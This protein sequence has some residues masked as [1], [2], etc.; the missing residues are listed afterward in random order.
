MSKTST[1]GERVATRFAAAVLDD[2]MKALLLKLRKG[3]DSSLSL[4]GLF[5]ILA[6]LGGWNVEEMVDAVP[7]HY[8]YQDHEHRYNL[9]SKD[10]ANARATYE[11]LK[12]LQVSAL[13]PAPQVGHF[14]VMD[15]Q[16]FA[17]RQPPWKDSP[18]EHGTS[19]RLWVGLP[20]YR[21]T[22]P[23]G[24]IFNLLPNHHDVNSGK[25]IL[26]RDLG[27]PEIDVKA[28]KKRL[29]VSD[30][31]RWLKKDTGYIQQINEL[32]GMEEHVPADK[33]T[34]ENTGSCGVC[35]R[36]IKLEETSGSLP[37]MA[38]HGYNRPGH[39]YIIGRC[40]GGHF[41]PYE[42]SVEATK[43]EQGSAEKRL[44]NAKETFAKVNHPDIDNVTRYN[45]KG[46]AKT[47]VKGDPDWEMVLDRA[48][49]DAKH[50]VETA[51]DELR[52]FTWL[53]DNWKK[54]ELPT[55]GSKE[56]DWWTEAVRHAHA[57]A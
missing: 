35:F 50:A 20:G 54:R 3:A 48:K 12:S 46:D 14:Y 24:K 2:K 25:S 16:P 1:P 39:G 34:R 36:N 41:A 21:I 17:S 26:A 57:K 47:H 45:F 7:L 56:I 10:E 9:T 44:K 6:L 27:L 28:L 40:P 15:L 11:K 30:T 4:S 5:K 53:V 32:L 42:L 22:S 52:I 51:E 43:I 18:V 13:P 37:R 29:S 55:A 49:N 38:L 19:Y 23:D 33:R 31:L 8:T